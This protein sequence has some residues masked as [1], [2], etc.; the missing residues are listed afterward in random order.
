MPRAKNPKAKEAEKLFELGHKLVDIAAM[1]DVPEGSVRRWKSTYKWQSERSDKKA[2]VRKQGKKIKEVAEDVEQVIK[3]K[4]LND[5]QRLFCLYYSRSFNATDAYQRAY[6]CSYES[7]MA[8]S[9]YIKTWPHIKAEIER[10]KKARFEAAML[11][12]EDI[13]QKHMEIAFADITS[14]VSFGQEEIEAITTEGEVIKVKKNR[15]NFKESDQVDGSLIQEVGQGK[16]GVKLKLLD[17]QKSLAWLGD[18]MDLATPEQVAK[19]EKLKAET[20]KIKGDD[21]SDDVQDDG[22]IDAL[23]NTATEDWSDEDS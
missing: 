10:L 11:Q 20:A 5:Q 1:L 21:L 15:V 18:H 13:F 14:Y 6:G 12:P 23:N 4:E 9:A 3:N 7:A 17:R 8:R 22:F 16:D 19:I 2:N